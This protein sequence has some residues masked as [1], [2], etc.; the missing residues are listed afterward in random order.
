[1]QTAISESDFMQ[2]I[3]AK[4]LFIGLDRDGTLVPYKLTPDLA[5]VDKSVL[6]II[7]LLTNINNTIVAIVSAR[8]LN[9]LKKDFPFNNIVLAGSCGLE[10]SYPDH[11]IITNET[12]LQIQPLLSELIDRLK[13]LTKS[14]HKAIIENHGLT[15]CLHTKLISDRF[16]LKNID[17]K[18][19][20]LGKI[21][22]QLKINKLETTYEFY[23]NI[24]WS[25]GMAIEAIF[26]YLTLDFNQGLSIF[27][28]DSQADES[29]YE[30][31][32]NYKGIS[33]KVIHNQ[34]LSKA[35]ILLNSEKALID[36][37]DQIARMRCNLFGKRS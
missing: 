27:V 20:A 26:E 19:F 11:K 7:Q 30:V 18:V 36:M 1:M 10:I 12:A 28:G 22:P 6:E 2:I 33:F 5:Y 9:Q 23:P 8:G 16:I 15:V 24:N 35:K 4:E 14:K 37:L 25:K 29:A 21:F 34:N 17:K 13:P 32:N 3:Q 31:I